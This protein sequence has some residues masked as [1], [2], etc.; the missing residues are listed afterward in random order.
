MIPELGHFALILALVLS[1]VQAVV[2]LVGARRNSMALMAV[3]RPAAQGQFFFILFSYVCLTWAFI[4]SDFS[5][6]L[7]ASNSHAETPV[8]YKITGVWGNHEGSLLLW[9]MSLS[10]W[11]VAVTVFSRHLPDAF[12]ARVLGVLG[13][14]SAG[15]ISFTLV[16]SHPFERLLPGVAEGRDLNPLLQDPGMIIHPPLL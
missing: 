7:A 2:P 14:V 15:F 1:L 6:Q 16:T 9:A 12:L 10:L 4:T 8:M 3:G 13:M 11:T 5:V